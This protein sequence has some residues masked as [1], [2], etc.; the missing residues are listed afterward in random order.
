M[1]KAC[2]YTSQALS[3]WKDG[4]F[5]RAVLRLADWR[6]CRD[7]SEGPEIPS[8][9]LVN[10]LLAIIYLGHWFVVIPWVTLRMSLLPK[11]LGWAKTSHGQAHPA[12]A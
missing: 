1:R 6:G 5:S 9:S 10:L 4:Y 12:Q 8:A 7:G 11:R 3:S 2:C